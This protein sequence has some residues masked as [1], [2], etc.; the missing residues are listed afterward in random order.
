[1]CVSHVV[2]SDSLRPHGVWPARL[3]C[4]W[5]SQARILEWV[6]VLSSRDLPDPGIEPVFL[7]STCIGRRV[8]YH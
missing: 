7:V 6:V 8:L 3:L 1:M 5:D 4:P 2:M